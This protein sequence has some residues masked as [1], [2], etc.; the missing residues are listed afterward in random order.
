MDEDGHTELLSRRHFLAG[1]GA[2]TCLGQLSMLARLKQQV[3]ISLRFLS[4]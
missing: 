4:R 3:S 2:L 1:L